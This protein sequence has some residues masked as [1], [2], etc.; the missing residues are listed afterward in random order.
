MDTGGTSTGSVAAAVQQVVG[1]TAQV[2][3][4]G[5]GRAVIGSSLTAVDLSGLTRIELGFAALLATTAGALLLAL[6]LAERRCSLGIIAALGAGRRQ[7]A[8]F[9]LAE[10]S[11]VVVAGT[12]FGALAGTALTA[13][14][15]TVL[16]G[17][18]V[19]AVGVVVAAVLRREGR[20]DVTALRGR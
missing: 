7:L 17:V 9:V 12:A 2:T 20:V 16:T 8:G 11:T 18:V 6:G 15:V 3:E 4:I 13:M 5:T 1:P 10:A 14:L 19:V